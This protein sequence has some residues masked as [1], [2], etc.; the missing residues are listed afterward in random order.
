MSESVITDE[1][2]VDIKDIEECLKDIGKLSPVARLQTIKLIKHLIIGMKDKER[3]SGIKN[4]FYWIVES[5]N[6]AKNGKQLHAL[7]KVSSLVNHIEGDKEA[8]DENI[9]P[10]I[11]IDIILLIGELAHKAD[12]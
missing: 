2:T 8:I 1:K 7:K 3:D 4:L 11:V 9:F 5:L 10:H 12:K 6:D